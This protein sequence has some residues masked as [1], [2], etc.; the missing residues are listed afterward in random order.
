MLRLAR[1]PVIDTAQYG[2]LAMH[3]NARRHRLDHDALRFVRQVHQ[4]LPAQPPPGRD[5]LVLF[6][7]FDPQGIVDPY[8]VHYLRA[9]NRLGTTIVFVSGSPELVPDSV[10]PLR[11]ICA[12]IYTRRTL[13]LDFGS[14][15]LAWS[16][17]RR[18]GW[19]LDQFDRLVLANDSV[20]GPL[21]PLEEMWSSFHGAD[22]YG[23]IESHE[24]A[25]HLQSFFLAWDL[26]SRT[27]PF[28]DDFWDGFRYIVYKNVLI[29]KYELGLSARARREGLRLKPFLSAAAIARARERT[30]G[31][32]WSHEFSGP[33]INNTLYYWDGLIEQFRYPFLKTAVPRQ[34]WP[35]HDTLDHLGEFIERRTTYPYALLQHNLDRLGCAAPHVP[36][37]AARESH[38]QG[39]HIDR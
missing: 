37:P 16:I 3:V 27:R 5:A 20:F 23:S 7:H 39:V 38:R 2:A 11:S 36:R 15:H 22:M 6:A 19:S 12:G 9:L 10:A 34:R 31:H 28:L 35:E 26:N 25:P 1:D 14:W 4:E 30:P 8:V 17:L 33:P 32:Q 13:S 29:K 18:H 21:F 24:L